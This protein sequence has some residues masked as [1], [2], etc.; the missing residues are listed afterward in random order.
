MVKIRDE[1]EW[2]KENAIGT[3]WKNTRIILAHDATAP[4]ASACANLTAGG[5]S[6]WFLPSMDELN[7]LRIHKTALGITGSPAYWSSSVY[8]FF[9]AQYMNFKGAFGNYKAGDINEAY[10]VR[11]VRSF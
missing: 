8:T 11:A 3:G 2:D 1:M 6:D 5:K 4:A 7:Q 10:L 9:E